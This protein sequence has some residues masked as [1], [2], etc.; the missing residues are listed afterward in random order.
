VTARLTS[1]VIVC[2]RNRPALLAD[3]VQSVLQGER[4]PDELVVVDQ[5]DRRDEALASRVPER[6]CV[7]RYVWDPA[8]GVSRARNLGLETATTEAVV[9]TDDDVLVDRGWLAAMLTA[10][11]DLGPGGVVTGRV[12]ATTGETDGGWAPALV[13]DDEP[14]VYQGRIARDVLEAGNM[15]A[16]RRT[17]AELGGFDPTLGPGTPYPA[18]EDND[19]GLRLLAAGCRIRYEPRALIYHRAWRGPQEY[20]PLR[21]RYGIGQGAYYAKH[22]S[23]RDRYMIG[24]LGRL[25]RRHLWLAAKRL[26]R[27]PRAAGGHLAY[28]AGVLTGVARRGLARVAPST[29]HG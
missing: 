4:A 17:L 23:F 18:G 13:D 28:V 2:S 12:L 8:R 1:A 6:G 19:M 20:I 16:H 21:W 24:R 29:G 10:L 15:A 9:F 7:V 5:S 22:L 26:R 25:L 14:A 3:A 11:E 27:E